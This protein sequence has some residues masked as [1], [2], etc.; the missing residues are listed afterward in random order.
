MTESTPTMPLLQVR[1]LT[2][3]FASRFGDQNAIEQVSLT[4][5][6]GEIVGLVGESGAGKSTI[7]AAIMGLLPGTGRIAAGSI[8]IGGDRVDGFDDDAWHRLRGNSVSM[9]FQD[10]QT[11]LNP[12]ITVGD[13]LVETI[14]QHDEVDEDAARARAL[15]LLDEVGIHDAAARLDDYPHTFSGGM[16]QRVVIALALCTDPELIIADEPT[17]ALDVAIQQ[18]VLEL[19]RR[20]ATDRQ[21]GIVLITHDIGVIAEITD[22]VVVL[23]GG[24]VRERGPTERVLGAPEHA[25][26]RALMAAV[27]RLDQR[28]ERFRGIAADDA[29]DADGE[30]DSAT[31]HVMGASDQFAMD[32]LLG[33]HEQRKPGTVHDPILQVDGLDVIFGA[34]AGGLF[35][36]GQNEGV[37]A[38]SNVSFDV[39]AGSTLGLVG[40]SGSG[41]STIAKVLTGLVS[42]TAGSVRFEGHDLPTG[43]ARA[44]R[45]ASRR[46]LQMIFQDPYSSLNNRHRVERILAEPLALY[47]YETSRR[48]RRRLVASVLDL[49]GLPQRAL[50]RYPHQFSGGQR[51][52]IAVAR[53]L[54]ARPVFLIADEPTSALDVS[55]QAG[56]L[57]LLKDLQSA[58]GL[59]LLFI[60][61]D[62][63]VVRQM[64]DRIVVLRRGA[65]VESGDSDAFFAG[66]SSDYGRE[67]LSL[68]PTTSLLGAPGPI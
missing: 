60:S 40:E 34:R 33:E 46:R 26:T 17:T 12:L 65:V 66:P 47:G 58:F 30:N 24:Q 13:Q 37:R 48:D 23:Q 61:H 20:L 59:S 55:V 51:Q 18:Q 15:A 62:L 53:A 2:V 3:S 38:V 1:D 49:T 54:L 8:S 6:R 42:P 29:L 19:I 22:R 32:W 68:S 44:R 25:Y 28:L 35:G 64:A 36:L 67:L 50:L 41:K 21:V 9:I 10:P 7:G 14:R 5:E 52:R 39:A 31:W 45:H 63:A 57:N 4:V 11:S 27:P 43:R 56:I 16:R